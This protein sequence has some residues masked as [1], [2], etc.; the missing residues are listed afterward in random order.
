MARTPR[1]QNK[2]PKFAL[3][4]KG[5]AGYTKADVS[6]R[7]K[8]LALI[9]NRTEATDEDRARALAEFQDRDVPD[10]VTEDADSM[11]SMSRDPSDPMVDRGRQVPDY[12]DA[13]EETGL[14]RLALEGVEEAQHEQMLE[15]RNTVDEPT[16]SRP[17]RRRKRP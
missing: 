13:D 12:V 14:E 10:T 15:S 4:G 1:D 11:Q 6:R 9:A 3:S 8:E 16:R 2:G 5:T 17:R 7:A